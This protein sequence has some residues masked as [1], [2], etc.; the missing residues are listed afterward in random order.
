MFRCWIFKGKLVASWRCCGAGGELEVFARSSAYIGAHETCPL[1]G[2]AFSCVMDYWPSH[3][4]GALARHSARGPFEAVL[5]SRTPQLRSRFL[6]IEIISRPTSRYFLCQSTLHIR[7]AFVN[8]D[9]RAHLR[10]VPQQRS[11]WLKLPASL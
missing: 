2:T 5:L 9:A 3:R 8:I 11:S 1:Y 6:G 4:R 10:L 7:F